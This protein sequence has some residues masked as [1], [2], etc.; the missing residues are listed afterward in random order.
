MRTDGHVGGFG[1]VA[2]ASWALVAATACA[3]DDVNALRTDAGDARAPLDA[4]EPN[5]GDGGGSDATAPPSCKRGVAYNHE[6]AADS[7]AL[8]A[9]I[10]WWYNWS[11]TPDPAA[12]AAFEAAGVEF[13]PM[14]WS[15]PPTRPIDVNAL[16]QQIPANARFL[17]GFNEPNFNSQANLTPEQAA[18]AWPLLEQVAQARGL[19]LV[20][21]ALNYCGGGC[22][23]TDPF[24]W[25]DHFFAACP[26][27]QVD[28]VAFH[29][30]ACTHDALASTLARF[31]QYGRP[32][33]LTEFS[34]LDA[35]DHSL[36]VQQQYM[37]QAVPLL[38][39]DP[40]V[41]RYSWFIGRADPAGV[42][43]ELFG[44]PGTLNSLGQEYVGFAGRCGQ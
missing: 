42:P 38:E 16:I 12:E 25:L 7:T 43:Y 35:S 23:E 40:Q 18:A 27:C 2:I 36:P 11:P 14:V 44:S 3:P 10:G 1:R 34:C 21:P 5:G 29:W 31:E 17:L 6:N 4:H 28:Y 32:V 20:S 13:V 24:V 9:G 19:K 15:G 8:S 37:Q 41:F 22:N 33:W 39:A 26:N 30:Y